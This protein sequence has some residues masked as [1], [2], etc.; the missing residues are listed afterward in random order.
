MN[1][2]RHLVSSAGAGAAV[3]AATGSLEIGTAFFIAGWAIDLDH[4]LDFGL[5][6]GP[7]GAFVRMARMGK[8]LGLSSKFS[9]GR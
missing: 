3:G 7:R 1:A 9:K 4:A 2:V 8:F 5:K 6:W